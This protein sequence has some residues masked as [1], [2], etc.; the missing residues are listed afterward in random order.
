LKIRAQKLGGKTAKTVLAVALAACLVPA[1]AGFLTSNG[2]GVTST[3]T[4]AETSAAA[5]ATATAETNTAQAASA[6]ESSASDTFDTLNAEADTLTSAN[7]TSTDQLTTA[8]TGASQTS[9]ILTGS[10]AQIDSLTSIDSYEVISQTDG[11]SV[12]AAKT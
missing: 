9:V 1:W 7:I 8:G 3:L 11:Q 5:T 2:E 10:T 6:A 12:C 4:A